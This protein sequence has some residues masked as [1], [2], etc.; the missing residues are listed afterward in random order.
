MGLS[1]II[2]LITAH[3]ESYGHIPEVRFFSSAPQANPD[4]FTNS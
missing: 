3:Y 1:M 2:G 4:V